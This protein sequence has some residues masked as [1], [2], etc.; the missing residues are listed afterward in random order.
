MIA[1]TPE[2]LLELYNL[3]PASNKNTLKADLAAIGRFARFLDRPPLAS[4]LSSDNLVA[5]LDWHQEHGYVKDTGTDAVCTLRRI[6][7]L[8]FSLGLSVPVPPDA[9]TSQDPSKR[10]PRKPNP[11]RP[12]VPLRPTGEP[13]AL[14]ISSPLADLF[15]HFAHARMEG[16][17]TRGVDH[18]PA[19]IRRFSRIMERETMT[20]VD[21]TDENLDSF[22]EKAGRLNYSTYT[23]ENTR[24]MLRALWH[25][26]H[27][28]GIR[29]DLPEGPRRPV[30]DAPP[31]LVEDITSALAVHRASLERESKREAEATKK[32]PGSLGSWI[33]KLVAPDVPRKTTEIAAPLPAG[34][35]ASNV[36]I[37]ELLAAH[38]DFAKPVYHKFEIANMNVAVRPLEAYFGRQLVA[39]FGPR[40]LK[41]VRELM[42]SGHEANG[43][44][45]AGVSRRE[46]NKRIGRI[47]RVFKWAVSEELAPAGL[48]HA[49]CAVAALRAG[50]TTA[51]ERPRV[52][53]VDEATVEATLPHLPP[54]VADMVRLQL[55]GGMRPGEVC[56]VRPC[57]IDRTGETWIYRP[58]RHKGIWRDRERMIYF[59]PKAQAVL[60]PYLERDPESYCFS[61]RESEL[62]RRAKQRQKRKTAVQPTQIDRR[63]DVPMRRPGTSYPRVAYS[64][65]IS[66]TCERRGLPSWHPNQLRHAAATR[67]RKEFGLD[68]AQAVLGHSQLGVTQIYAERDEASAT[69]VMRKIG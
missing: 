66:R 53:P 51:Y 16:K 44:K 12:F 58:H 38:R 67:I 17:S 4:D 18:Y 56:V 46:V 45:Y 1:K 35:A 52:K 29:D 8:A 47:R 13:P 57:D 55:L 68:A 9:H 31:P 49:L 24:W 63:V 32:A 19:A 34:R 28:E 69:E 23:I 61:P 21:L 60:A 54:V 27:N 26:A 2:T 41:A 43:K 62:W 36:T 40:K 30:N 64:K 22:V 65:A 39:E 37:G 48:H 20:I 11:K 10:R 42:V 59:G 6:W 5:L 33:K 50:Q 25:H 3:K 7:R 14:T 15:A